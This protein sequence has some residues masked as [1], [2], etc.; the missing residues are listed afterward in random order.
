MRSIKRS[1]IFASSFTLFLFA[2]GNDENESNDQEIEETEVEA[3]E[4]NETEE[5]EDSSE[6]TVENDEESNGDDQEDEVEEEPFDEE[7]MREYIRSLSDAPDAVDDRA[8]DQ[9]ELR[10]IHENTE[11]YE[12]RMD[13][14]NNAYYWLPDGEGGH[15]DEMID[16]EPNEEGYFTIEFPDYFQ[17]ENFQEGETIRLMVVVPGQHR[18]DDF[19]LPIHEEEAGMEMIESHTAPIEVKQ[20]LSQELE[21]DYPVYSTSFSYGSTLPSDIEKVV[22]EFQD[23]MLAVDSRNATDSQ[24]LEFSFGEYP[25]LGETVT[26][27]V[28]HEGYIVPVEQEVVEPDQEAVQ[29]IQEGTTL[30]ESFHADDLE[31][32][33]A[34]HQ[35]TRP[36]LAETVPNATVFVY[37]ESEEADR[38]QFGVAD[39]EGNV[40][41]PFIPDYPQEGE[42]IWITVRDENGVTE[43]FEVEVE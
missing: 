31:E 24:A 39:E 34:D 41:I 23:Q 37:R 38:I 42:M 36:A 7:E 1:L 26:F 11:L 14:N 19:Y 17:Q 8:L 40:E 33:D 22:V 29:A 2:C 9:L 4:Q 27:H 15:E 10:G 13:P 32:P 5:D 6:E 16:V 21:L 20:E 30:P 43:T 28:P 12:G 25:E 35:P 18:E 3:P